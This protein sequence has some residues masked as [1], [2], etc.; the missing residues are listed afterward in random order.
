[1]IQFSASFPK[2]YFFHADCPI[3]EHELR[4]RYTI[5]PEDRSSNYPGGPAEPAIIGFG[6]CNCLL[7]ETFAADALAIYLADD[8]WRRRYDS[9]WD[10]HPMV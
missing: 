4:L 10:E 7:D 3:C 5:F 2:D 8:A 9:P 1:M 6:K